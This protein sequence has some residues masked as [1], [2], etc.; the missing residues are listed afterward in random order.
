MPRR[1]YVQDK[2]SIKTFLS[3]FCKEDDTGK[4][5]FVYA[6]Q[7]VKIAHREQI[8]ITIDLDHVSEFNEELTEAIISNCRR[9]QAMFSDAIVDLLPSFKER[10]VP[11]KDA[12]DVYI[13][14]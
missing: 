9:Y 7:L 12:L 5:Q 14:H 11:A 8:L 2:E 3:E 4:K 10:E 13:E 6:H 1:D